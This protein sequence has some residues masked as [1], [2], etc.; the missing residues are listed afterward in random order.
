MT[1][2]DY[3][4]VGSRRWCRGC[5]TYQVLRDGKWRDGYPAQ[6]WPG[7]EATEAKCQTE[8]EIL[9]TALRIFVGCA[10]PVAREIN[11]R[12][13]DWRGEDSLDYALTVARE[14]LASNGQQIGG[15]KP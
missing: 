14:A 15:E 10:Y 12:G 5:N 6:P 1:E 9:R 11:P 8:T 2:H 13:H 3:I 7:Y 4:T